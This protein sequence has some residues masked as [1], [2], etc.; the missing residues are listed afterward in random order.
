MVKKGIA[1]RR[2]D[3]LSRLLHGEAPYGILDDLLDAYLFNVKMIPK[4][5]IQFVPMLTLGTLS[6]N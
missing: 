5:S 6:L 2:A 4:W 1:H 3:H